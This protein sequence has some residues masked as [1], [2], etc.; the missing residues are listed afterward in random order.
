MLSFA[1]TALIGNDPAFIVISALTLTLTRAL[2]VDPRPYILGEVF[3]MNAAGASTLVGSFVNVLVSARFNLD[4]KY[5]LSYVHFIAL[6]APFAVVC[7]LIAVFVVRRAF[8]DAF[9]VSEERD[10]K[11][12]KRAI[13]ALDEYNLIEDV[14][15]F[16]R[17][18]VLFVLTIA[19]FVIAGTLNIPLYIIAVA[20][21]F[22]FLLFSGARPERMLREVDWELVIFL[23][24]ILIVV[25]GVH[26]TGLLENIGKT[27]GSLTSGNIPATIFLVILTTGS[28]S[29]IMDNVSVTSALLYVVP[30]LSL[31]ALVL[32]KTVIWA[33]IYG[34]N[35][36]ANLTPIGGIPN[37]IACSL[38][39]RDGKPVTWREFVKLG[40]P[41][42]I[43]SFLIGTGIIYAFATLL[44]WTSMNLELILTLI[45]EYLA[46]TGFKAEELGLPSWLTLLY[47]FYSH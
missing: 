34:A 42:C 5:F 31:N 21:A 4:P 40:A 6:G 24:S 23:A 8:R 41:L 35:S 30:P 19:G 28:L 47:S 15:L 16:R 11:R 25:E 10:V 32:D 22:A 29:G 27:L 38:L 43:A 1:L 37:L 13:L 9:I 33:L 45:S 36:G 44:G 39:E 20:S 7:S 26:S 46:V 18:C 12:R 2:G 3:V 17:I 14:S